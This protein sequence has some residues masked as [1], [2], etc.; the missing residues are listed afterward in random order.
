MS[1]RTEVT[2]V[3][4]FGREYTIRGAGSPAYIAEIAHYVDMK[5]RQMTDN[6]TVASTAKVAIFAA[7]N[8]ADELYQ[9]REQNQ[10]L[11]DGFSSEITHLADRIEQ[12][13]SETPHPSLPSGSREPDS[14]AVT[15]EASIIQ[16]NSTSEVRR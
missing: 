1:N 3:N 4:I 6:A 11:E 7:L 12:V 8:I 14:S 2:R 5:M 9:K 15:A 16:Q 13:L 10:E